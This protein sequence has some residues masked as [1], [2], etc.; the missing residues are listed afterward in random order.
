MTFRR[1]FIGNISGTPAFRIGPPGVDVLAAAEKDLFFSENYA[2]YRI[3]KRCVLNL[4]STTPVLQPP[5]ASTGYLTDFLYGKTFAGRPPDADLGRYHA[6]TDLIRL[7]LVG[8]GGF[9]MNQPNAANYGQGMNMKVSVGLGKITL[10]YMY[11][12]FSKS[13]SSDPAVEY[14][15]GPGGKIAAVVWDRTV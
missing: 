13:W 9:A 12:G 8:Q 4:P 7:P 1:V 2:A 5:T 3:L 14:I 10:G 6:D 11:D 15:Y